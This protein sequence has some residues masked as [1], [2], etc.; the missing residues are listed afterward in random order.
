MTM[1]RKALS[2]FCNLSLRSL[3]LVAKLLLTLYMTRY[4]GLADLGVY[5]LVFAVVTTASAVMGVQ[6]EYIV[7]RDLVGMDDLSAIVKIKDQTAF[8]F[9]NYILFAF[10]ML[11]AWGLGLAS[12][13][14][15]LLTFLISIA[16]NMVGYLS[17]NLVAMERPVLSTAVFFLRSGLW[18]FVAV[19]LGI[20]VPSLR[21]M[22]VV[23]ISWLVGC[24]LAGATCFVS[25][26]NLPWREAL[27]HPVDWKWV[28]GCVR[29]SW[30]IWL[31]IVAALLVSNLDRFSVSLFL[32]IE[33]LGVLTFYSSFA[34]ALMGLVQSGVFAFSL[35]KLVQYHARKDTQAFRQEVRLMGGQVAGLVLLAVLVLGTL[36]PAAAPQFGHAELADQSNALWWILIAMWVR[37]CADVFYYVLYAMGQDKV[38]WTGGLLALIPAGLGNFLFVPVVGLVGVGYSGLLAGLFLM[39]WRLAYLFRKS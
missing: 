33:Q 34:N 10:V 30:L 4:L 32:P 23:F 36:I 12:A 25:L 22:D 3:S 9:L 15:L 19:F 1:R 28:G 18:S 13:K 24:L 31:A 8:Y 5:G 6:L 35:P 17:A 21:N 37:L 11:A 20:F 39:A 16:D 27:R 7:V 29:K 2:Q 26:A 14:I 38:L